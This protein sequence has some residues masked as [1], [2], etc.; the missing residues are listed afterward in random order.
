[1]KCRIAELNIEFIN[2]GRYFERIAEKYAADFSSPD[3]TLSA[4]DED[5]EK[6]KSLSPTVVRSGIAESTVFCRKLGHRMPGFD[7]YILHAATFELEGRGIAFVAKSGTGKSTHMLNWVELFGE[8]LSIINGDKPVVRLK[9]GLPYA[10]GAPW[11]GKEGLSLNSSTRLTDICF[12]IR[13]DE[14]KIVKLDKNDVITRLLEHVV[15][16]SGSGN[17]IKLLDLI[18]ATVRQCNVW[19]I[20]CNARPE[21]AKVSSDTIFEEN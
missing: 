8:K 12:I 3:I 1:M 20:Y 16:P 4:S 18:E 7:G 2:R 17:I 14:N 13:S 19:E 11:C 10:Y 6:E 9:D 5:I 15:V 21:S